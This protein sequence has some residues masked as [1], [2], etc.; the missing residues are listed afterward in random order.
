VAKHKPLRHHV[1]NKWLMTHRSSTELMEAMLASG[2][3]AFIECRLLN[4]MVLFVHL[5]ILTIT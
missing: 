4:E 1:L 3:G 2:A 5:Q